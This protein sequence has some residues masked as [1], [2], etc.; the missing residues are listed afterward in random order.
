[1]TNCH[2]LTTFLHKKKDGKLY[3]LFYHLF[4]QKGGAKSAETVASLRKF[5]TRLRFCSELPRL[6]RGQTA[7]QILPTGGPLILISKLS[8]RYANARGCYNYFKILKLTIITNPSL[9][10]FGLIWRRRR[11]VLPR[12]SRG[13]ICPAV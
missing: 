11:T 6:S 8:L 10:K 1:M 13:R 4:T 3:L 7:E 5:G 9:G 12:L 2:D